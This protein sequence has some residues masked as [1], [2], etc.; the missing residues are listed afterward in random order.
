MQSI[1]A[2]LLTDVFS[3]ICKMFFAVPLGSAP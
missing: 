3:I 1:L 2:E